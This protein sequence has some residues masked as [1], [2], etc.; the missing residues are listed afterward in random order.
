MRAKRQRPPWD[1]LLGKPIE[2]DRGEAAEA[3]QG[4]RMLRLLSH[5]GI[6]GRRGAQ[7]WYDLA[8]RLGQELDPALGIVDPKPRPRGKTAS[9]RP[10]RMQLVQEVEALMKAEER[11]GGHKP[12]LEAVLQFII[13]IA[14][15]RWSEVKE[16]ARARALARGA[17]KSKAEFMACDDV[18][19]YVE[20]RY[21]E[22]KRAERKTTKQKQNWRLAS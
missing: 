21:H 1:N 9:R 20:V 4:Q 11:D 6:E 14:P 17:S 13:G 18:F 22:E 10:Y 2:H 5:Y 3:E 16:R 12:K 8:L 7:P 19:K 15:Q